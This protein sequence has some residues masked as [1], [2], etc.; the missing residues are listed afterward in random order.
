[1]YLLGPVPKALFRLDAS[2]DSLG[3][4]LNDIFRPMAKNLCG[5]LYTLAYFKLKNV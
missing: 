4:G 5:V 3:S 2:A 1:M